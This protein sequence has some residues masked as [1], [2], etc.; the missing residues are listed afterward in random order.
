VGEHT[1]PNHVY[2]HEPY[3]FTQNQPLHDAIPMKFT[4]LAQD[5]DDDIDELSSF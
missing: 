1:I 3:F 4:H 5:I 2:I